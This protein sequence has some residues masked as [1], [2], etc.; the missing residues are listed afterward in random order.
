[1]A[2]SNTLVLASGNVGKLKEFNQLLAPLGLDVRAQSEFGVGD[3]EETGLTFVENALL[4]ARE[5]S[6]ISGLPALADDSG[7]EV[8]ALHGAPGI[9]SARYAG[10]P[11]SDE[12]NN[13]KLLTSLSS[14]AEGQRSGRYWCVLVY[15]RHAE[16]PVPVI[17]QRSWEGEILAHPRGNGGFGYDPLFWLPDQGMS[18]AE[19]SSE[20]KN[21]LS[22]RGRALQGLVELLKVA[23]G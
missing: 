20:T 16:D 10:E 22:H 8:D 12:R 9:Y 11:K 13:E 18:V 19:L 2:S 15:L 14:Y 3:V 5:A 1:M 17:V 23:H 7:L 21:R 4:K 6:R